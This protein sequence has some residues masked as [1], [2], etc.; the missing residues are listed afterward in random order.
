MLQNCNFFNVET[1]YCN[2]QLATY[3][4]VLRAWLY[5]LNFY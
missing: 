1:V 5:G 2:L 4:L 3:K